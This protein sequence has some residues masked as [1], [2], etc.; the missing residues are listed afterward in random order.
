M[1]TFFDTGKARNDESLPSSAVTV[2]D[3]GECWNTGFNWPGA[4]IIVL[5][6]YPVIAAVNHGS[7]HPGGPLTVITHYGKTG[8]RTTII[9]WLY[10]V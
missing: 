8:I 3:M 6:I 1:L 9:L 5:I 4:L 2:D 10:V 7:A